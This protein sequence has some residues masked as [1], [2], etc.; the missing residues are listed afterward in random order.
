MQEQVVDQVREILN[1]CVAAKAS[2]GTCNWAMTFSNGHAVDGTITWTLSPD[3]PASQITVPTT[4]WT[5][6]EA[7]T[8][9]FAL[10]YQTIAWTASRETPRPFSYSE[11]RRYCA[12]ARPCAA[13]FSNN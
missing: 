12:G 2:P 9:T 11:P 10:R 7:Y 6:A 4:G 5:A 3:D 1:G 8:Q 13:A